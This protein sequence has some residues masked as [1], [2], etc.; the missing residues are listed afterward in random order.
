M[1]TKAKAVLRLAIVSD[2]HAYDE[3]AAGSADSPSYLRMGAP[4]DQPSHH[5]IAGLLDLINRESLSVDIL[6]CCGDIGDKAKPSAT[7]YAWERIQSL[8]TALKAPLLVAT[9]G[10]HDVD[11]RHKYNEH[12]AK[13]T[14][15]ALTPP[16][17]LPLEADND[18]FWS[19]N[20]VVVTHDASR[21]VVLNSSA[22][23]GEQPADGRPSEF[24]R[25]RIAASTLA[26]LVQALDGTPPA[27]VNLLVCHHHPHKYGDIQVPDYSEMQG[28]DALLAYLAG[29]TVGRWM[30]IHGHKHHPRICYSSGT[31]TAPIIFSAGSLCA[32]LYKE[33]QGQARNQ[34][35]ILEI[36]WGRFDSLNLELAGRFRA[37]DWIHATGWRPAGPQSGLPGSGGFGYRPEIEYDV[38]KIVKLVQK[39]GPYLRWDEVI[40]RWPKLAYLM[41]GDVETLRNRLESL[42]GVAVLRNDD[43]TIAQLAPKG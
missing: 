24:E 19:K 30:V 38:S 27:K 36:P 13:G 40:K 41:P 22:Y 6:V 11:S 15:Q 26:R 23:H 18:K 10:N 29:G 31:A 28:G 12:D 42:A 3:P 35:Y 5:P 32:S 25:G 14:L 8:K 21:I 4:E 7:K 9:P 17:P 20:F 33:I 37:W 39:R 2:L 34:F 43:G 1:P 16:F